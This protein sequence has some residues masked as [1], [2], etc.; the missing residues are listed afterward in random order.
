[1]ILGEKSPAWLYAKLEL[2]L[3]SQF[4]I[5]KQNPITFFHSGQNCSWLA[6]LL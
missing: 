2:S 4:S 6:W 1:M 3:S 5:D